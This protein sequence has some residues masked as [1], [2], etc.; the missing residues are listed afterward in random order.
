VERARRR[1]VARASG[2]SREKH[3][4]NRFEQESRAFFGRV[5]Q[6]Y[7]A[8]AAREPERVFLVDARG[9]P[10]ETHASIVE[11]VRRKLKSAAKTG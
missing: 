9:T 8:I 7:L 4:E 5:R 10:E 11:I 3:D 6:A 2:S 1:N